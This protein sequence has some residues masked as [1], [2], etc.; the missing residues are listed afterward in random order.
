MIAQLASG[1][2]VGAVL[3]F[4]MKRSGLCFTGLVYGAV[5]EQRRYGLA[6]F[7]LVIAVQAVLYHGMGHA[8]LITIPSFLPSFSLLSVGLGSLLFGMGAVL[9]GGC[10]VSTLIK[11]G[12]GRVEGFAALIAFLVAGYG[13]SAG[14]AQPASAWLRSAFVVPDNLPGRLGLTPLILALVAVLVL[15]LVVVWRRRQSVLLVP[16]QEGSGVFFWLR[17]KTWSREAALVA[18]AVVMGLAFLA[19]QQFGRFYGCTTAMP[20]LSWV[21]AISQPAVVI[22][23][24]NPYDVVLG[25]ASGFVLGIAVGSLVASLVMKTFCLALPTMAELAGSVAGGLL[26]GFGAVWGAGCLVS[27][28]L[29]GTAQFSAKSWWALFFLIAGIWLGGVIAKRIAQVLDQSKGR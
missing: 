14:L 3:G 2:A 28:G 15:A 16:D 9:A 8:G 18:V 11:C 23:G 19:S 26:M 25:W 7:F 27:N 24:C 13:A 4:P 17:R 20:L 29:V 10:L 12:D 1:F 5:C 6:L 22:G 21:F